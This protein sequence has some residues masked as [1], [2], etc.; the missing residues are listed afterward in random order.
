MRCCL[1]ASAA[2][3]ARAAGAARAVF[4]VDTLVAV[5]VCAWMCKSE[6]A[7]IYASLCK[8]KR[9]RHIV[10]GGLTSHC[11]TEHEATTLCLFR[12]FS[13]VCMY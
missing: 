5:T 12:I 11:S 6:T 9:G 2:P 8:Y 1:T 13:I 7:E 4:V 10:D 3:C